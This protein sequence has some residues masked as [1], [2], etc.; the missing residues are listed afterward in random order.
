MQRRKNFTPLEHLGPAPAKG[1]SN[2]IN[3]LL[4]PVNRGLGFNVLSLRVAQ[5]FHNLA[6]IRIFPYGIR[7]LKPCIYV[8][9]HKSFLKS[10]WPT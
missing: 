5:A 4:G 6:S 3:L 8:A 2:L 1:F 9:M 7:S 10:E